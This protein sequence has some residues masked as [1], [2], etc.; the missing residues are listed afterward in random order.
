[1]IGYHSG[2][3]FSK[4]L[5]QSWAHEIIGLRQQYALTRKIEWI[6]SSFRGFFE[7]VFVVKLSL[8]D[9]ERFD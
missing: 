3:E 2:A 4:D 1:V 9:L 6:H 8:A 7:Y 5:M